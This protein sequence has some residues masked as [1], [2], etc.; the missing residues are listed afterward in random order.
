MDLAS[1]V[2]N[3]LFIF[4]LAGNPNV[5][6]TALIGSICCS[7]QTRKRISTLLHRTGKIFGYDFWLPSA[8][9]AEVNT[10]VFAFALIE[11][12]PLGT[13]HTGILTT[14][15]THSPCSYILLYLALSG[16]SSAPF[17]HPPQ[18]RTSDCRRRPFL[19]STMVM[20]VRNQL[21]PGL[22]EK[23]RAMLVKSALLQYIIAH[24]ANTISERGS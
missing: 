4:K 9:T 23:L 2:Q 24:A 8:S 10:L 15:T 13:P 22:Q 6:I 19:I 1:L 17:P 7:D 21:S 16:P 14:N 3:L 12:R 18:L 11:Y 20:L 5:R